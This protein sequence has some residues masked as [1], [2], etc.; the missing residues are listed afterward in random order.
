MDHRF[1]QGRI[2]DV[3][4]ALARIR[5]LGMLA[6]IAGH[7]PELFRWAEKT[8]DLDYYLCSYYNPQPRVARPDHVPEESERFR[9]ED[10]E[11]MAALIRTLSRPVIHYKILAAGRNSPREAF[12]FAARTMRPGDAVCVGVYPRDYPGMLREDVDLFLKSTA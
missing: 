11:E 4:D 10:R 7:D 12:D 9:K 1:A 3:P 2:D 8:L 5:S 6:G